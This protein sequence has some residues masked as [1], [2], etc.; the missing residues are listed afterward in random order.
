MSDRTLYFDCFSGIAGD[1]TLGALID[2][3]VEPA[4]LRQ[5]LGA[6]PIR[7]WTLKVGETRKQGLRGVDVHVLV[8]SGGP[9]N[10]PAVPALEEGPAIPAPESV[11][12]PTEAAAMP[13]GTEPSFSYAEIVSIIKGDRGGHHERLPEPVVERSLAAF[14]LLAAAE[15]RVHGVAQ[16]EVHFHEVG[17]VDSIIDI[18][19]A[20]WGIWRL[21][22]DR[23]ESAPLPMGRG[24]FRC[25]HGR[26]PSPAPATLEILS[27]V[28]VGPCALDREMVTPT[29]AAFVKAWCQ[30]VGPFPEMVIERTGWGAGDADFPDRPNLLRLVLGRT[31][32]ESKRCVVVEANVDDLNPEIA[33]YLLDRLL[34]SGARDAWLVPIHMK[35]NRPAFTVSA[36]ADHE[37]R[38][39]VEEILLAE[40]S[41]IGLRRHFVERCT[42]PRRIQQIDTPFGAVPVKIALKDGQVVNIAPEHDACARIARSRSVPLKQVYQHAVAACLVQMDHRPDP[43]TSDPTERVHAA[44]GHKDSGPAVAHIDHDHP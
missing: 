7:G 13:H 35:K 44:S 1:M 41:S 22:V 26:M 8:E 24:F 43:L 23:V 6:L 11:E 37:H 33:G 21:G 20:A 42:L 18:V 32:I 19:G 4:E 10:G 31:H 15:A 30:R 38:S 28:P 2:L 39:V 25:A 14:D 3:G 12:L 36:L 27:G 29:G 17:A 40:S 16:K 9:D 5:A 34:E